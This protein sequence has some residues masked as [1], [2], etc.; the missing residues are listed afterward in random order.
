MIG[1]RNP[2]GVGFHPSNKQL[3]RYLEQKNQGKDSQVMDI[4]PVIPACK[5]EPPEL[6]GLVLTRGKFREREW[7]TMPDDPLDMQWHFFSPRDFISSKST[8]VIR[9]TQQGF[10]KKQGKD[11][12]IR[13]R[14]SKAEIGRKRTLTFYQRLGETKPKK[15]DW[16]I[17]EYFLTAK[18]KQIG[19]Y[20]LCRLKN[21]SDKSDNEQHAPI[22]DEHEP[23]SGSCSTTSH[24]EI[25]A[26]AN[27]MITEAA[28][29]NQLASKE[30][31]NVSNG[32]DDEAEPCSG[33]YHFTPS[34]LEIQAATNGMITTAE[35]LL[36][37]KELGDAVQNPNGN[38]DAFSHWQTG[39]CRID[40]LPQPHPPQVHCP[41]TLQSPISIAL[42]NVSHG[43]NVHD[44]E[45]RKRKYPFGDN[46]PSLMKKKHISI[47]DDDELVSNTASNSDNQATD[48]NPEGDSVIYLMKNKSDKKDS[49]ICDEGQPSSS[50]VVSNCENQAADDMIQEAQENGESL[51]HPPPPLEDC[52]SLALQSPISL[53]LEVV[54]QANGTNDDCN[55]FQS[56]FRDDDSCI[57]DKNEDE[58]VYDMLPKLCDLPDVNQDPLFRSFQQQDYTSRNL[59]NV[60]QDNVYNGDCNNWQSACT[61]NISTNEIGI[62]VG[63]TTSNFENQATDYRTLEAHPQTE[64][65][66]ESLFYSFQSQ[67]STLQPLIDVQNTGDALHN[68]ECNELQSRLGVTNFLN[69]SLLMRIITP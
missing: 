36:A 11:R 56:P 34:A 55:D 49:S 15:T 3:L 38:E 52:C 31:G 16:V 17:H 62:P 64:G 39:S 1:S 24:V 46:D 41:S 44:D 32:N 5:N 27:G 63:H 42:G 50:R 14:G 51:L 67:D 66:L 53:E 40:K 58:K 19:K 25:Q 21:K 6:P 33:S 22:C 43:T 37:Y 12:I 59:E 69:T 28:E 26:A 4:M 7:F 29:E 20:V 45:C 9:K 23:S 30:L 2:E 35:E 68:I 8:R 65:N 48:G 61:R 57:H 18:G 60:P 13:A 47:N 10:W 54:L